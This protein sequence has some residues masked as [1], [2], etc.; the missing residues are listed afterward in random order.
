MELLGENLDK[1]LKSCSGKFSLIT[2]L[3]L[4]E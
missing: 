2:V 4:F 3:L 1:K